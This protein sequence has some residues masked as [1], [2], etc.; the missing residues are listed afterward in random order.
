MR[1]RGSCHMGLPVFWHTS[2]SQMEKW[3]S[4][5]IW[6][7]FLTKRVQKKWHRASFWVQALR[8]WPLWFSVSWSTS[9]LDP[10]HPWRL[11]KLFSGKESVCQYRRRRRHRFHPW[12]GRIPWRR[13][14]Q[15]TPVFLLGKSH[16][17]VWQATVHGVTKSCARLSNWAHRPPW[18]DPLRQW[19]V[20]PSCGQGGGA[21]LEAGLHPLHPNFPPYLQSLPN[22][23]MEQR[24]SPN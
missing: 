1:L 12:I 7:L 16:R 8:N 20:A 6:V 15:P 14:W 4:L 2:P 21:V 9:S 11:P 19:V 17:G 13:K 5:W 23:C 3:T 10:G 18:R 22:W 24:P